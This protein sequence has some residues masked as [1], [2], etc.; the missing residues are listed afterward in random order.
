MAGRASGGIRTEGP[1]E[2]AGG[3]VGGPGSS[4]TQSPS[5]KVENMR[6]ADGAGDE[7]AARVSNNRH[8]K[9]TADKWNQ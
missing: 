1:R 2:T 3:L 7:L 4:G 8:K 9:V 6:A 5:P